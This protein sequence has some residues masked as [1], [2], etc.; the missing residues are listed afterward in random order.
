VSITADVPVLLRTAAS[1][2]GV[3]EQPPFSNRQKYG[4]WYGMNGAAW[5]AMFVSWVFWHSGNPLPKITTSKGFAYV[6]EVV[7]Y[8]QETGT[9]HRGVAGIRP[10]DVI[11]FWFTTRPDHVGIVGPGGLMSDGRVHTYEGNTNG[12]GSRTGGQVMQLYR[13]SKIYGYVRVTPKNT[14]TPAPGPN[15]EEEVATHIRLDAP[16][17]PDH[18][19]IELVGDFHRRWVP[20]DEWNL[21]LFL[22]GKPA[23]NVSLSGWKALTANKQVIANG[24]GA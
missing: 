24:K 14:P 8:G 22:G 15:K 3:R 2:I 7:R 16:G 10:G 4:E 19:R 20:A 6:P 5:C 18:G 9:F 12:G 1:Q 23:Q 13:R 17:N 21:H 11:V